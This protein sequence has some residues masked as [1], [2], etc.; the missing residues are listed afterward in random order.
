MIKSKPGKSVVIDDDPLPV[1]FTLGYTWMGTVL[2]PNTLR[3]L[4]RENETVI[5]KGF[6]RVF[7]KLPCARG[8]EVKVREMYVDSVPEDIESNF[9]RKGKG[10]VFKTIDSSKLRAVIESK[11]I[12]PHVQGLEICG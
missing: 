2:I 9:M 8:A 7:I 1:D 12:K 5:S 4:A 6:G 10:W 3:D 11:S